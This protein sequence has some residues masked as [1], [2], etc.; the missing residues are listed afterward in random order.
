MVAKSDSNV[1]VCPRANATL[2]VGVPQLNKMLDLGIKPLLGSD[3]VM[4]NSPNMFR[5]LEFTLKIMSVCHKSYLNPKE[6]LKMATTNICNTQINDIIEKSVIDVGNPAEF[7]VSNSF[8]IDPYLNMINR[9]ES[10][11]IL[12]A[13]NKKVNV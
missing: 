11:N 3:N 1:V 7:I 10:K 2:N 8:S 12:Y 9:C 6:L 13:I 5:E 4:L